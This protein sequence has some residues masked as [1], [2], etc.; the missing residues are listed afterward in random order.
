MART[1][2]DKSFQLVTTAIYLG[3]VAIVAMV[4]VVGMAKIAEHFRPRVGDVIGFER[5]KP[6]SPDV[7]P[8][9]E[10]VPAGGSPAGPCIL[11]ARVMRSSGGS[12]VI[13]AA[14][15]HPDIL[16]RVHWAGGSTSEAPMD[17]GGSVDLWLAP[18]DIAGLKMAAH[19]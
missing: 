5:T 2:D 12:F 3:V 15:F 16:Y 14:H 6:R 18:A 10:V 11:D 7:E 4:S 8:T 19:P 13:E 17:C 9:I 1:N